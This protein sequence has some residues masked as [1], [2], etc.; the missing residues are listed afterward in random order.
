MCSPSKTVHYAII[1]AVYTL[2]LVADVVLITRL[3]T[4]DICDTRTCTFI[5][6]GTDVMHVISGTN[7]YYCNFAEAQQMYNIINGTVVDCC[8]G[9]NPC[10]FFVCNALIAYVLLIIVLTVVLVIAVTLVVP[11]I[12]E[13]LYKTW[14][15]AKERAGVSLQ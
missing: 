13:R 7:T 5:T 3:A 9:T 14:I 11:E 1:A 4:V 15:A 8:F 12:R 10:P 2:M 6:N